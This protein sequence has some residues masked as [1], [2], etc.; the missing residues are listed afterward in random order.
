M[1][2]DRRLALHLDRRPIDEVS[3]AMPGE[4]ACL[5]KGLLVLVG[6]GVSEGALEANQVGPVDRQGRRAHALAL[7]ALTPIRQFGDAHEHFLGIAA[8]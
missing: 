8:A 7:H 3:A 5:R 1:A 4:D 6:R 2:T